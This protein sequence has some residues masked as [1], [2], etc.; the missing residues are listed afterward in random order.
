[1]SQRYT[2]TPHLGLSCQMSVKVLLWAFIA[3]KLSASALSHL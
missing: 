1:M 3:I 2:L